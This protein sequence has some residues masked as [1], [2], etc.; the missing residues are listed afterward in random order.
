M[1]ANAPEIVLL[2]GLDGTG[3]LFDW[4][5]P[6]LTEDL[7]VSIVRYPPDPTLGYAGYT[8][9]V[10]NAIGKR[11]VFLLGESFSGPVAVRVAKQLGEQIKG[12]VLAATFVK[13]PWPSWLIR[14]AANVDPMATPAKIRNAIL[15]GPY[16]D[17]ELTRRIDEIVRTIPRPLRAARFRA[18]ADVD[19]RDDFGALRCP[20]LALHGRDDW[21]VPKKSMQNAIITKG[22]ARMVVIPGAHMLLQTRAEA[23]AGE[24]VSFTKSSAEV[25]YEA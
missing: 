19:V 23:A 12:I 25:S 18:M 20:V 9:L 10:R 14:R 1:A 5:T 6:F 16:G 3:D 13:N 4:V 2:P 15:I 24:I 11:K 8:E 17:A 22:G 21:L 7:N